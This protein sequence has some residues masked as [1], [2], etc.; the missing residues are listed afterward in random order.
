MARLPEPRIF[1]GVESAPCVVANTGH[2][3]EVGR[4]ASV[5]NPSGGS[6]EAR[7]SKLRAA[8]LPWPN[9]FRQSRRHRRPHPIH[10]LL[11]LGRARASFPWRRQAL[12]E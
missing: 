5:A 9:T 10:P 2:I 6:P 8:R 11:V 4:A 3:Q 7:S 12:Q 1:D